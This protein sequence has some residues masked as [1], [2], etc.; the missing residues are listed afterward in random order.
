[1]ETTIRLQP[2][3][4]PDHDALFLASLILL[5][6]SRTIRDIHTL[7][8]ILLRYVRMSISVTNCLI[9]IFTPAASE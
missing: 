4:T 6:V 8:A 2:E 3:K 1:M 5:D 9:G 7:V